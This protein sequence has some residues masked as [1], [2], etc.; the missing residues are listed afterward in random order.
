MATRKV[1]NENQNKCVS[2]MPD[3][4]AKNKAIIDARRTCQSRRIVKA[5]NYAD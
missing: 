4:L 2:N 3:N 5:Y 1:L